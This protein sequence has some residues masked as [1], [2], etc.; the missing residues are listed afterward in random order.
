MHPTSVFPPLILFAGIV[1]GAQ[2]QGRPP[3]DHVA[4]L[5]GSMTLEEKFWQL[6]MLPGSPGDSGHDYSRGVFGLQVPSAETARADADRINA[7]QRYFLE[8]TRLAIP[9]IPFEEAV[10]GLRRPGA[11]MFP[12]AIALAATWDTA[13]VER[14]ALAIAR[15]TR[16][17]GI[18][19][20]LSPVVNIANDVRWGRVEETY[21]ED[22]YLVS[23][24]TRIYVRTLEAEGVVT[25]PKHFVANVGDGGRDSWPIA[26]DERTLAEIHYPPFQTALRA[27]ARS[28]MTAYNSVGGVPATQNRDLLTRTLKGQWGFPGFV[29]SDASATGGATVLHLTEPDTRVAAQHAFDAGLDVVFQSSWPEHRPYLE[30]FSRDLIPP[31]V[32][33][34]ALARVLQVKA[35]LGI[36]EA[37]YVDPDSAEHW[38]GHSSHLLLAREV[39]AAGMVLLRNEGGTLPIA[40]A[41]TSI[42]VIGTDAIETRLGGYSAP[43]VSPVSILTGLRERRG[44]TIRYAEGPGRD[45]IRYVTIPEERLALHAAIYDNPWL[46]GNPRIVRPESIIDAR[47]TFNAPARGLSTDWYSIRWDGMLTVGDEPV[48]RLGVEGSDGWRLYLNDSLL[49]DNWRKQSA[50]SLLAD[51]DLS[52][53]TSHDVKLEYFETTGNARVRLVWDAG[54]SRNDGMLI[55]SAAAL[56]RRSDVAIIV[57]GIEEGEF[58]DRAFL[59]LPGRQEELIRAVAATGTPT[60]VVL[61][62]GSAITMPWLEH[63]DAVL[64]AWYPGEAG[65]HALADVILGDISPA[66]RLP[67]TFPISEGQLPLVYNHR[68][69]GRGDDYVDLTGQPLF[70]FGFGLS[71]TAFEYSDLTVQPDLLGTQDTATVRLRVRNTGTR[72][73]DE[74]VQLYIR[75]LLATVARPVLSLEGFTRIHLEPG[76]ERE[77][78]FQLGPDQLALLD[79]DLER[80]VEPGTF[81]VYIGASS[82]DIRLRGDLQVR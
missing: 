52:P 37:P 39:A 73:G 25:T 15:E 3:V 69:T 38:N 57:A 65:G 47:W 36:F 23:A 26:L 78:T 81:R 77:I 40:S 41:T 20:V 13:L 44:P 45:T 79:G 12:Q 46:E 42:G 1:V 21:G 51:V 43:G 19:Q 7:V 18:R 32:I 27:G 64:M 5:M 59:G 75:D 2:A 58:R 14:V 35:Q 9:I 66:G 56:A 71:Y 68:P 72:T 8:H 61:V 17:R 10:H 11:T 74:V 50:G 63:V 76:E 34:S 4:D 67:I 53:R 31:S 16:S 55:D 60:V 6:F 80:V 82:R 48:H 30:A 62:G 49:I 29:I 22:P 24:M 33:D 70:P 54:V 28:V